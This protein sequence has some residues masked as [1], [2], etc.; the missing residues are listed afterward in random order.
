[1]YRILSASKDT[2]ITDKIIN[3]N[4]RA[5]DANVGQAGTLDVFK[6]FEES[7]YI[8]G[9]T[10]ITGSVVELSRLLIKFDLNEIRALTSS[11]LD[12]AH[13]SFKCILK[14]HDVYGGQTTPSNF[15]LITFPLSRS[16]DEGRGR[17]VVSF[18]DVDATNFMTSSVSGDSPTAWHLSGANNQGLLGDDNLD[19]IASGNLYDGDGIKNLWVSQLFSTGEE[20]LVMD[21]T[22]IVPATLAGQMPDHGFRI[23]YS[24]TQETDGRTRFVKRFAARHANNTSIRPKLIVKYDDTVIDHHRSFFFN[25]SGSLFLNNRLRGSSY[26]LLTGTAG[27]LHGVSGSS[28]LKL[29]IVSGTYSASF[30]GSQHKIGNNFVT[31][32]YSS[33]FLLDE[34]TVTSSLR[35]EIKYAGSATFSTYWESFDG[36]IGYYTGSFVAN[37]IKRTAFT[38]VPSRLFIN[39]TNLTRIYRHSDKVT[40]RVFVENIDRQIVAKKLPL[41]AKSEIYTEMFYRVRDYDSNT[42]I[43]PFDTKDRATRLSTDTQGMYFDFYMDSLSKGRT[44]VFDFLIKDLGSDLVFT[45]VAAKFRVDS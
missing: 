4:F 27:K 24:G 44:Y 40:L 39:I 19:I 41:E 14:L 12:Y 9:S 18:T 43:I 28:C 11:K 16:F 45:D 7:S 33:S 15:K 35:D 20:D 1:M 5:T 38:N 37:T 36:T 22:T 42:V 6:L 29:R 23:S 34:F 32:V 8:S 21:V 25:T 17:D 3:N 30:T 31:G 2:Y 26:N 10:R 13:S